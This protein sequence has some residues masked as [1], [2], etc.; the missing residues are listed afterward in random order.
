MNDGRSSPLPVIPAKQAFANAKAGASWNPAFLAGER[1]YRNCEQM[2]M[3]R[4]IA[5]SRFMIFPGANFITPKRG[6]SSRSPGFAGLAW[7]E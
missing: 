6:S 1:S 5:D 4:Q 3:L 2:S 7:L